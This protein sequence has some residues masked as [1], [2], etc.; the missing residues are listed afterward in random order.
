[1]RERSFA[2]MEVRREWDVTVRPRIEGVTD[3]EAFPEML[4]AALAA[5]TGLS[6]LQVNLPTAPHST[7]ADVRVSATSKKDAE[8]QVREVELRALLSV[9]RELVGEQ[10]L[11]WVLG[12]DAAPSGDL[13]VHR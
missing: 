5:Q 11:G 4:R 12:T 10:A 2:A 13:P 6:T 3:L 9:A 8:S 7:S 1:M